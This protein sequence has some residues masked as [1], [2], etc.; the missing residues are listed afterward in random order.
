MV[1]GLIALWGCNQS[2]QK[3]ADKASADAQ[4]FPGLLEK[5]KSNFAPLASIADNPD[6]PVTAEKVA[7]GHAL[8]FDSRL[9]Q[10]GNISCNSCHNLDTYGVDNKPFSPGDAGELGG[11]NSPTVLNAAFQFVQFWDGRAKDVEEQA[12]GPI[13]NPVEMSMPDKDFVITRI[14]QIKGYQPLFAAAFPGQPDPINYDNVQKAIG[15]FERKLVTPSRFDEYLA[16]DENALNAHE[17]AGLQNFMD[18]NCT[19]CHSGSLLGGSM[20][21]KFGLASN[22]WDYTHSAKVD[23]GRY[24]VTKNDPDKFIFKVSQLRNIEKTYP[25]F[26]DGSTANLEEAVRIMAK[27]QLDNDLTQEEVENITTFLKTLTGQVPA[28]LAKVPPMPV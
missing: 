13:L 26:H 28:E 23:E 25:Y 1:I 27:V 22:Y 11:R 19:M 14:K 15:D 2:P 7:L 8:Y 12:G 5:A 6:N 4:K 21:M 10:A 24:E 3:P 18:A 16:G 9:S 17:K 20:F